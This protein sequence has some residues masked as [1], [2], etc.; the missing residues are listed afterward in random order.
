M[1]NNQYLCYIDVG[2]NHPKQIFKHISNGIMFKLFY[3]SINI[4]TQSK[5]DYEMALENR[6]YKAKVV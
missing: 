1:K 2:S 3:S 6:G 5:H 4:F